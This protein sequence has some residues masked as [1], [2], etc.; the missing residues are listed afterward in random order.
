MTLTDVFARQRDLLEDLLSD[1][2]RERELL[3]IGEPDGEELTQIA[4]RKQQKVGAIQALESVR[5]QRQAVL[6]RES[7]T[8]GF[9]AALRN[10]KSLEAW[11]QLQV[12]ARQV[13]QANTHNGAVVKTR[14]A[15]NQKILNFITETREVRIYDPKGKAGR[16]A[17]TLNSRA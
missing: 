12:L 1:L 10:D 17:A 11:E 13:F 7:G 6:G 8:N 2:A 5:Q 14:M 3:S 16:Q 4:S 15:W 9:F